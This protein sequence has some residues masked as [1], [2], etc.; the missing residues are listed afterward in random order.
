[1]SRQASERH[2]QLEDSLIRGRLQ[3]TLSQDEDDDI[4]EEMAD[5]WY[6]MDEQEQMA[7]SLRVADYA[8]SLASKPLAS[9]TITAPAIPV[10]PKKLAFSSE[11]ITIAVHLYLNASSGIFRSGNPPVSASAANQ[12][13]EGRLAVA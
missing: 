3:G 4:S 8:R 2:H 12:F 13:V 5:L 9:G 6:E 7:A 10:E 11:A 1:M